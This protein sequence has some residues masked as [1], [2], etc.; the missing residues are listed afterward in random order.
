M[1]VITVFDIGYSDDTVILFVQVL[2]GEVRIIDTYDANGRDLEHYADVIKGKPWASNYGKHWLPHDAQAKT[3]AAAGRSVYEQ[4]TKDHGL[5]NVSILQNTNT[6]QQGIMAARQLFP[7]LWIDARQEK[8]ID[9]LTNFRREWDDSKKCFREK[10]VHDWTNHY[11]DAL[12]YLSWVWKEPVV[13]KPST[14]NRTLSVGKKSTVTMDDL[15]KSVKRKKKY[16]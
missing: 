16:D 4:F 1:P 10:P 2:A 3:L 12:R 15:L 13:K 9:A 14:P 8:F 5:E 6:E 11:A 7:R